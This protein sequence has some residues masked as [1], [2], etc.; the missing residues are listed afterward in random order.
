MDRAGDEDQMRVTITPIA[1]SEWLFLP[2]VERLSEECEPAEIT[3]TGTPSTEW[4][5]TSGESLWVDVLGKTSGCPAHD[6]VFLL[7]NLEP[8]A[9][10]SQLDGPVR[11]RHRASGAFNSIVPVRDLSQ[12]VR[13]RYGGIQGRILGVSRTRQWAASCIRMAKRGP[14]AGSNVKSSMN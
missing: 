6:L 10:H 4:A 11:A 14:S 5:R 7:R 2:S 8:F 3:V 1:L 13:D 9:G 12:R